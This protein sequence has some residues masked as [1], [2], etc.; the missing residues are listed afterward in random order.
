MKSFGILVLF[1]LSGLARSSISDRPLEAHEILEQVE[2]PD[3]DGTEGKT[4]DEILMDA[5][6]QV[7]TRNVQIR[8]GLK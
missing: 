3:E 5:K 6:T 8:Y 1:L 4:M 2:I 7:D